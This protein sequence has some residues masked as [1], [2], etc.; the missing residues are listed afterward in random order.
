MSNNSLR[1]TKAVFDS[2]GGRPR[3]AELVD[4]QLESVDFE[5]QCLRASFNALECFTNRSGFVHGGLLVTMLD[6]TM[7]SAVVAMTH[8]KYHATSISLN[9]DFMRPAQ[10]GRIVGDGVISSLGQSI[11]FIEA[12]LRNEEGKLLCRATG[13]YKLNELG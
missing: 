12:R 13:S 10:V 7:G 9:T 1:D 3:A 8:G 5:Q 4:W 11:A 2:L 6:E